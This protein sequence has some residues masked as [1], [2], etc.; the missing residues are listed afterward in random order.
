MKVLYLGH[1]REGSGWSQT[2]INHILALDCV[3]VDVACRNVALTGSNKGVPER[4]SE[5]ESKNINE[6][7]YCI[8]H[9]LP[10]HL[11]GTNQF[12]K[13]VAYVELESM[14]TRK[15]IWHRYMDVMDEVWV[16]NDDQ[17]ENTKK[18]TSSKVKTIPH[19][20]NFNH[21]E[22]IFNNESSDEKFI[23]YSIADINSRK[24]IESIIR[25]YYHTF[26]ARHNVCLLLKIKKFGF[27]PEQIQNYI[28]EMSRNIMNNMRM[29]PEDQYPQVVI[30]SEECS[31]KEIYEIHNNSD[32]FVG[33]SRGEAWSLPAFDAMALGNT[34]ICS[35]EGG[36]KMFIDPNNKNTGTLIE[37][38][39]SICNHIDPA[40]LHIFTGKEFWFSPSEF[41]TCQAMSYYYE[42][43]KKNKSNEGLIQSK[44]FRYEV[45]GEKMK[46]VL[47]ERN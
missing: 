20:S 34:P 2:A 33:I 23:F 35:N 30:N 5:L 10:H 9:V 13:N 38:S 31:E 17:N 8:Q 7:D 39:Y 4:I 14:F 16:P 24:N 15:N 19:T 44:K 25:C 3:G 32:C 1:Y 18:F 40:F 22:S 12:K 42:N 27:N 47:N 26:N 29:Q 6:C 46:E 21:L 28:S 11:I 37:G 41:K 43:R 36:P 45:I